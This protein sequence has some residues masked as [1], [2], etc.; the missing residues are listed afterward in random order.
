MHVIYSR[1][2]R[3]AAVKIHTPVTN[4]FYISNPEQHDSRY[5]LGQ[6]ERLQLLFN[7]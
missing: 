1:V 2:Y 5:F 7:I 4:E 6:S 3:Y